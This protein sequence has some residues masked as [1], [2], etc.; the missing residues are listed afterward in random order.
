MITD[1][2]NALVDELK[3]RESLQLSL[4]G[5]QREETVSL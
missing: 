5:L 4:V 3:S 1:K 2:A